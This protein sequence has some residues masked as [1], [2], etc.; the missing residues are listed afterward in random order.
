VGT[1]EMSPAAG[2]DGSGGT[3]RTLR[4][5]W[6]T[7]SLAS[8]WPFP[9][10]WA[11][12]AVDEVC[13]LALAGADLGPGLA[14]L[15]RARAEAGAGLGET[16]QDLAAL[17]AVLTDPDCDGIVFADPDATPARLLRPTALAWADVLARQVGRAELRDGLTGLSSPGYL[18]ARLREVYRSQHDGG[19]DPRLRYTLIVVAPDLTAVPTWSGL[20]AMALLADAVREV[21]P[22]GQTLAV[23][24]PG[25]IVVLAERGPLL[26]DR[27]LRLRQLAAD[28]FAV[29][30]QLR[31]L[32][33]PPVWPEPLPGSHS[34]ACR[35]LT[36]LSRR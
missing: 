28:R 13:R 16:C 8:G 36:E 7:A 26:A 15:G 5:R 33:H 9:D 30:P 32:G 24:G 29:D 31:T 6:R 22:G 19:A 17:H 34:A 3:I 4:S 2:R 12:P 20:A 18:R 1:R 23:A 27:V 25:T 14:R 35:L 11:V 21:F 10:D